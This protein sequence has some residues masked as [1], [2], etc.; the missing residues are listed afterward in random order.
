[1]LAVSR[2]LL[3]TLSAWLLLVVGELGHLTWRYLDA[4]YG[5]QP[6]DGAGFLHDYPFKVGLVLTIGCGVALVLAWLWWGARVRAAPR[7]TSASA[8]LR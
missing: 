4:K 3:V 7:H 6:R 1:M 5:E 2:I 8:T